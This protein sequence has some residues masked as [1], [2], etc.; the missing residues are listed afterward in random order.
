VLPQEVDLFVDNKEPAEIDMYCTWEEWEENMIRYDPTERGFGE[1]FVYASCHWIDHFGAVQEGPFPNL[2]D[3]ERLCSAGSTRLYNWT[4]QNRRPDCVM[5]PRFL[6][7]S[8]SYDPLSIASLYG[9]DAMLQYMLE[10]FD[11]RGRCYL[12]QTVMK[13]A[14]QILHWGQPARLGIL[15]ENGRVGHQLRNL[16]LFLL[17]IRQWSDPNRRHLDW[18]P[19]FAHIDR[20]LDTLA[21]RQQVNEMLRAAVKVGCQPIVQRLELL[22]KRQASSRAVVV[23][24]A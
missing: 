6:F 1:F 4:Q 21:H 16:D 17:V 24:A 8:E 14:D 12:P 5:Q 20:V 15:L 10:H 7:D 3:L 9:S 18:N 2:A 23:C 13:A 11:F 22:A 19:V